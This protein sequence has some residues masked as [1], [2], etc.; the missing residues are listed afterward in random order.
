MA[1]R[2]NPGFAAA[3][4]KKN[5][6]ALHTAASS[7]GLAPLLEVSTKSEEA[8]GRS[9]SAFNLEVGVAVGRKAPIEVAYQGSKVFQF[10]GPF[11]DLFS[12]E[13][14]EAKRDSRLRESGTLVAFEFGG[15]R[16]PLNPPTAFYDWLFLRALARNPALV[17]SMSP[18][19]GFTDIEFNPQRSINC[20]AR[21]CATAVSLAAL[22]ELMASAKSF[23][24]FVQLMSGNT[25]YPQ[26]VA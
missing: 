3:Q 11:T 13:P 8:L 4:K 9:L 14:R 10:G 15:L 12:V 19:R 2:W 26:R 24:H 6:L 18:Y 17:E 7:M 21:S 1:F 5:V 25:I 16:F 23:A 20:Q 22:G